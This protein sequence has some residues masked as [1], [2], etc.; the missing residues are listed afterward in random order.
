MKW[1]YKCSLAKNQDFMNMDRHKK[2]KK[3]KTILL[4]EETVT[5][6][7]VATLNGSG[8]ILTRHHVLDEVSRSYF[9]FSGILLL[10]QNLQKLESLLAISLLLPE[11]LIILQIS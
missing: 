10:S 4:S 11:K 9:L 5:L 7:Q 8:S 2:K 3:S 1:I 6:V